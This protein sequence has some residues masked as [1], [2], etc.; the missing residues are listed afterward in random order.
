AALVRKSGMLLILFAVVFVSLRSGWLLWPDASMSSY[1]GFYSWGYV[2]YVYEY[3][4]GTTGALKQIAAA[5]PVLWPL[6]PAGFMMSDKRSRSMCVLLPLAIAQI[7]L[8]TDVTRMTSLGFP[9]ILL[10]IGR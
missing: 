3:F 6:A 10:L 9:A 2:K 1:R 8:A 7:A 5:F 4:G